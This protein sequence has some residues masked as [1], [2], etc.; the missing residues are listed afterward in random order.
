MLFVVPGNE[1]QCAYVR[2]CIYIYIYIYII[3]FYV[4]V[5]VWSK[6][7]WTTNTFKRC[8]ANIYVEQG[9]EMRNTRYNVIYTTYV[10]I[11]GFLYVV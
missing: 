3:F 10:S 4:R 2:A 11:R 9:E 7:V 1:F 6:F 8:E 5:Y